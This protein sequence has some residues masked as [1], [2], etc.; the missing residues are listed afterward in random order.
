VDK[1][2][3]IMGKF[4]YLF[5]ENRIAGITNRLYSNVLQPDK[6]SHFVGNVKPGKISRFSVKTNKEIEVSTHKQTLF[7]VKQ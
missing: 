4:L 2:P 5:S 6:I 7:H 1:K 3:S